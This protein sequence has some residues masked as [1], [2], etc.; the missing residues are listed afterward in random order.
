[1]CLPTTKNF[2]TESV[3]MYFV[4]RLAPDGED[5]FEWE[6]VERFYDF[7]EAKDFA[8]E[9]TLAYGDGVRIV[10]VDAMSTVIDWGC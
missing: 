4:E 10:H 1:M 9:L 8:E 2:Q 7:Q 5:D 3:R 6:E